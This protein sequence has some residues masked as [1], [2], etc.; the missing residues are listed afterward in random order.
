MEEVFN[1]APRKAFKYKIQVDEPTL[2]SWNF[3]SRRRNV[4][5]GVFRQKASEVSTEK[6]GKHTIIRSA[7]V[8]SQLSIDAQGRQ[9]AEAISLTAQGSA[10][11]SAE[12]LPLSVS[13][14]ER[15]PSEHFSSALVS[16]AVSSPVV[17]NGEATRDAQGGAKG[18]PIAAQASGS[19]NGGP[20]NKL[21]Q[22]VLSEDGEKPRRRST[23]GVLTA[24][25]AQ[26]LHLGGTA[27]H[28]N[29]NS[30]M[31]HSD[32][33]GS[34]KGAALLKA[35]P[36]ASGSQ[37][38]KRTK[39]KS[40]FVD[41]SLEPLLPISFCDSSKEAV[42]GSLAAEKAGVYV[43]VFDNTFS[44]NRK[45]RVYLTVSLKVQEKLPAA[46]DA[47]STTLQEPDK[48]LSGW[49]LKK[50]NRRIA[51]W[52]ERWV[53]IEVNGQLSYSKSSLEPER[54]RVLLRE[55]VI[56]LNHKLLRIDID[57]GRSLFHFKALSNSDFLKWSQAIQFYGAQNRVSSQLGLVNSAES[58]S[59]ALSPATQR[60]TQHVVD[61]RGALLLAMQTLER[62]Y[63]QKASSETVSKDFDMQRTMFHTFAGIV[64]QLNES[65]LRQEIALN[66][67]LKDLNRLRR[68]QGLDSVSA[69]TLL[70]SSQ[71]PSALED[72]LRLTNSTR[73]FPLTASAATAGGSHRRQL[74]VDSASDAYF[75]AEEDAEGNNIIIDETASDISL[76]E[77]IMV[78]EDD[79]LDDDDDEFMKSNDPQV[80]LHHSDS[81]EKQKQL[82]KNRRNNYSRFHSISIAYSPP[83]VSPVQPAGKCQLDSVSG[84]VY[85]SATNA[86]IQKSLSCQADQLQP[87]ISVSSSTVSF[88]SSS[89]IASSLTSSSSCMEKNFVHSANPVAPLIDP[90]FVQR[91]SCLP[92]PTVNSDSIN[93]FSILK[94]NIGKD[95]TSVTMPVQL[96]E[97]L[98]LLQRLCEEV[99]YCDLLNLAIS[100]ELHV[101]RL[102]YVAAFAVSGYMGTVGR[103]GKKPWNPLLGE[104]YELVRPDMGLR[105]VAEKVSH[106]P[107]VM[108]C[109]AEGDAGWQIYQENSGKSKFWGKSME[110]VPSGMIHCIIKL[111]DGSQEHYYWNKLTSCI[112]NLFGSSRYVEYY[113]D[114]KIQSETRSLSNAL[115]KGG[116]ATVSFK[117]S[118]MFGNGPK[119]DVSGSVYS[120]NGG[121]VYVLAG[122]WDS[123]L[124]KSLPEKPDTLNV[125][126]RAH[127]LP[128]NAGDMYGFTKFAV[129]LNELTPDIA[130]YLPPTD[131]RLR[132]DQRYYEQG[133]VEKAE[134]TKLELEQRQRERRKELEKSSAN[135]SPLWFSKTRLDDWTSTSD[136]YLFNHKYWQDRQAKFSKAVQFPPLW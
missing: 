43:L 90:Q 119:Y 83:E 8:Q 136:E 121:K 84:S 130:P 45:K 42:V 18:S 112:R 133:L 103:I 91:R 19:V 107:P 24:R 2:I 65:K 114:I 3:S 11:L 50:K 116:T 101:D 29:N 129:E 27:S 82:Y 95:L 55:S 96:N 81:R 28:N 13:T 48:V 23:L 132:P 59:P 53:V 124:C 126:W 89:S 106:H 31:S 61:A 118:G 1:V 131:S 10:I 98:N 94:K 68:R 113:G 125:L 74:S 128:Q 85:S 20:Q 79:E 21:L 54:G 67:C 35:S 122:R 93:F 72:Q 64:E 9:A 16:P 115:V 5:F 57:A 33:M 110:L 120:P 58:L 135:Y 41:E 69:S 70:S 40:L 71:V 44:K 6:E 66:A 109:Y 39:R 37:A 88:S 38:G 56:R 100:S 86:L 62:D 51:G 36:S 108:A 63:L 78:D 7:S 76:E 12:P 25:T 117:D 73:G 15:P 111:P 127:P 92:A 46:K 134:K 102:A 99:E 104:T 47:G 4:A 97:P 49:L 34:I 87:G 77:D 26:V 52:V 60:Q 32:S 17:G 75:D 123:N 80:R 22:K 14:S 105:F 30:T